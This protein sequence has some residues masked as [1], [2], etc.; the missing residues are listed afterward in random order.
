[1]IKYFI[2]R[3]VIFKAMKHIFLRKLR[4]CAK[5][6][7]VCEKLRKSKRVAKN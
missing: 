5:I 3:N 7:D 4:N 2:R 6:E 1:M